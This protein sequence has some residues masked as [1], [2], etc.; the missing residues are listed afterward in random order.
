MLA[1]R[2]GDTSI[3]VSGRCDFTSAAK[4]FVGAP[5]DTLRLDRGHR[6]P[7]S[8]VVTIARNAPLR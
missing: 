5:E 7:T 8:R 3:G 6:I 4:P 2:A 1:H